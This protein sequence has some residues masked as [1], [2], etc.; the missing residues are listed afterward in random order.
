MKSVNKGRNG[1]LPYY[2]AAPFHGIGII[3]IEFGLKFAEFSYLGEGATPRSMNFT[4]MINFPH[5]GAIGWHD[6]RAWSSV[7]RR[8]DL[9]NVAFEDWVASLNQGVVAIAKSFTFARAAGVEHEISK[10]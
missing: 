4:R 3:D 1:E 7:F 10:L 9:E 6:H 2:M 5:E 8:Y